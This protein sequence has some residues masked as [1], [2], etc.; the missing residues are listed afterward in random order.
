MQEY[1]KPLTSATLLRMKH[2]EGAYSRGAAWVKPCAAAQVKAQAPRLKLCANAWPAYDCCWHVFL[3]Q[4]G[5]AVSW[6]LKLV[7]GCF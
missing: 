6:P 3:V 7:E 5:T 4:L 2:Y 1:C